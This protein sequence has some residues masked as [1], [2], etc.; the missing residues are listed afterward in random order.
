MAPKLLGH[1][2]D[3]VA[4]TKTRQPIFRV[5]L[6]LVQAGEVEDHAAIHHRKGLEAVASGPQRNRQPAFL[7]PAESVR[8]VG[9]VGAVDD[10]LGAPIE[11]VVVDLAGG[12]PIG[13]VGMEDPP[14]GLVAGHRLRFRS[15]G[16]VFRG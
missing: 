7:G 14:S 9:G 6:G 12:I 5:D 10:G 3:A 4:G 13:I 16:W 11:T 15:S 1:R 2:T 8:Y